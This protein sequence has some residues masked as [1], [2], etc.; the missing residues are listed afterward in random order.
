MGESGK[1]YKMR[2]IE[3]IFWQRQANIIKGISMVGSP[4]NK[5]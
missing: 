3:S 2:V 4:K 1:L 5:G